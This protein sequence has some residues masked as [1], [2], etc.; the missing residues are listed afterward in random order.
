MTDNATDLYGAIVAFN[1]AKE[2]R[3]KRWRF[4]SFKQI[5]VTNLESE[6]ALIEAPSSEY[7]R[8]RVYRGTGPRVELTD[9]HTSYDSPQ[10]IL[11]SLS[12]DYVHES[13]H[14]F[15]EAEGCPGA[16]VKTVNVELLVPSNLL[17]GVCD[18][19]A[20][21]TWARETLTARRT[22]KKSSAIEKI[23]RLMARHGVSF[24]DL[25]Q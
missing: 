24:D 22:G 21:E 10:H 19:D 25:K 9:A 2:E 15:D 1:I 8:L 5:L 14:V 20:F 17:R 7:P 11:L 12:I 23:R 16:P 4:S 3:D 6:R 18:R 13:V